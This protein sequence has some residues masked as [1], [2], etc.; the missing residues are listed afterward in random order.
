MPDAT[1]PPGQRRAAWLLAPG[2]RYY[3]MASALFVVVFAIIPFSIYAHSGEDWNFRFHRLL[4]LPALGAALLRDRLAADP[5]ERGPQPQ[6]R[7]RAR[8]SL[9]LP[10]PVRA[11]RP[12][13]RADP[14]RAARRRRSRERRAAPLHAAR[15]RLRAGFRRALRPAAARSRPDRRRGCSPGSLL[16]AATCY[17]GVAG[18]PRRRRRR[19]P[20]SGHPRRASDIAGA[21]ST[22]SC[23]TRCRPTPFRAGRSSRHGL[24]E[25]SPASTLF[26]TTSPTTSAPCVL[27]QLFHR[28]VTTT[29]A[30]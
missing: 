7:G 11:A 20:P 28:H 3:L 18:R 17:G 27:G 12:G 25:R 26:R 30:I 19:P 1:P 21:T 23:S 8:L 15:G 14:G 13:L 29:A 16:V 22:I 5:P 9:V 2:A 24:A 4:W 6:A 10:R